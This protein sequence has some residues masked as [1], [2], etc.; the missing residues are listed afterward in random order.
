[1]V[2][3]S[4]LPQSLRS[5]ENYLWMWM[6]VVDFTYVYIHVCGCEREFIYKQKETFL[7]EFLV[8]R[9]FWMYSAWAVVANALPAKR[10]SESA[11]VSITMHLK[12]GSLLNWFSM[13][14]SS[15]NSMSQTSSCEC[16]SSHSL[17]VVPARRPWALLSATITRFTCEPS[18]DDRYSIAIANPLWMPCPDYGVLIRFCIELMKYRIIKILNHRT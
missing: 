17:L 13:K 3:W 1:M 11:S 6:H 5:A 15:C 4:V 9:E 8:I 14:A 16:S 18:C 2:L 7:I 12:L 10:D